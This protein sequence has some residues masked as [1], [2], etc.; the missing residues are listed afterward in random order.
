MKLSE[1]SIRDVSSHQNLGQP[2]PLDL[3]RDYGVWMQ[4]PEEFCWSYPLNPRK[5]SFLSI[6]IIE[7]A[8]MKESK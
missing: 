5:T 6:A 8:T 2:W 7:E 4:S 3:G 1:C